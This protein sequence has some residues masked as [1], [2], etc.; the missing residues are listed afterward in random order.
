[1]KLSNVVQR[2]D[3]DRLG[4]LAHDI[5]VAVLRQH[6][7]HIRHGIVRL[8]RSVKE[9]LKVKILERFQ[10]IRVWYFQNEDMVLIYERNERVDPGM[11]TEPGHLRTNLLPR[12]RPDF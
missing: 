8:A 4:V 1:M 3:V 6:E 2:I 10:N 5:L 12:A 11:K 9:H 7:Q